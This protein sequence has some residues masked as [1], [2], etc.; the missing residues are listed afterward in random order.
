M[1]KSQKA[2]YN[3][4]FR[5]KLASNNNKIALLHPK[6]DKTKSALRL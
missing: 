3:L 4:I 5:N 2:R 6:N 1:E